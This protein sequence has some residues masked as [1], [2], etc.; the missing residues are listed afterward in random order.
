MHRH[1]VLLLDSVGLGMQLSDR[2]RIVAMNWAL[3]AAND[4]AGRLGSAKTG[5]LFGRLVDELQLQVIGALALPCRAVG[6]LS[7]MLCLFAISA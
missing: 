3:S 4:S 6:Q 5:P 2:G 7:S 1:F